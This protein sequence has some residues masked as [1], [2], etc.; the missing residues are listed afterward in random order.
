MHRTPVGTVVTAKLTEPTRSGSGS[1][2]APGLLGSEPQALTASPMHA[3]RAA[4]R[5]SARRK[6]DMFVCSF[7]IGRRH[8]LDGRA[9]LTF[10]S[11]EQASSFLQSARRSV[12]KRDPFGA[13]G[14]S[15]QPS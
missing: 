1:P 14:R 8:P 2:L 10:A 9:C 15:T 4:P 12:E 5:E 13:R 7:S 3:I 6:M 11:F